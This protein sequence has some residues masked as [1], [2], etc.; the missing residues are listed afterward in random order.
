LSR[1]LTTFDLHVGAADS[2]AGV[3]AYYLVAMTEDRNLTVPL[4]VPG[5][6]LIG[7][8]PC[9]DL[10]LEAGAVSREHARVHTSLRGPAVS[11]EDLGSRNGTFVRG[12]Q[13]ARNERVPLAIG[14]AIWVGGAALV[15]RQG[16]PPVVR[17]P[18]PGPRG[19]VVIAPAMVSLYEGL[20]RIAP[21][22]I[23][24]LVLGETGT[25]KEVIAETLHELSGGQAHPFVRLNCAALPA[26]LLE[27]ELF[28]S[29]KGAFTGAVA[30]RAGLLEAAEGGTLFL[31][32]VGDLPLPLQGK[33]LRVLESGEFFRLG[34]PRPRNARVRFVAATNRD[35]KQA[36]AG[37]QFRPDLYYRL[38]GVSVIVPPLRARRA[39]VMPLAQAFAQQIERGPGTAPVT[40]TPAACERLLGYEWPG[41]IREL[42]SLV[43]RSVLLSNDGRIDAADLLFDALG[44][45]VHVSPGIR[46]PS[47]ATPADPPAET[48]E[49]ARILAALE[50]CA[51]NQKRAAELL[52]MPRRTLVYKMRRYALPRPRQ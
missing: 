19:R 12:R 31:D 41:N 34:S 24:V 10:R 16:L 33:L 50:S 36:A 25:G 28:G 18:A 47:E 49:R 52:G 35:L 32:E 14:D 7:R 30:A 13:L 23:S 5:S 46:L 2:T 27:S 20:A 11:V 51:F 42:K 21:S 26:D 22:R 3:P 44:A 40:F 8:D 48:D 6:L 15:L 39:E 38:N 29:E 4:P 45:P 9:A 43:E 17:A 1:Q 37:G